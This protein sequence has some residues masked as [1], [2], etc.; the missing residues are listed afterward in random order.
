MTAHRYLGVDLGATNT[1]MVVLSI[2]AAGEPVIESVDSIPTGGAEGHEAVLAR[3]ID[4]FNKRHDEEGPFTALGMGTPGLFDADGVVEIFTNLPGQWR[5]VPLQRILDN[6]LAM[7]ATLINDARAFTLAE[8]RIGAGKGAGIVVCMTL[9]TGIG[10]GI[11]IDGELFRGATGF[12]GE[13]AHQTVLPDGPLCGCGNYGCAEG[14]ARSDRLAAMA[15]TE[16]VEEVFAGLAEGDERCADAVATA[17]KYLGIAIAN[18]ITFLGPDRVVI[19]GGIAAAGDAI[20][21]PI[22]ASVHEHVTLVAP[23]LI[24]IRPAVLG[25]EAGAVG[26]ALAAADAAGPPSDRRRPAARPGSA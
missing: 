14:V 20:F 1:K 22:R 23:E 7:S 12:A 11:M 19:G 15:G 16:T 26:A 9:G 17:G 10:G 4:V 18:A 21:D 6:G 8:G 13:I 5:G 24:D 25:S 3:M 2:P